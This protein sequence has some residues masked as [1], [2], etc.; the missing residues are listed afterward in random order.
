MVQIVKRLKQ[1]IKQIILSLADELDIFFP[2][3]TPQ[4]A[5]IAHA[6]HIRKAPCHDPC[7]Q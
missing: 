3:Q 2:F 1:T 6:A 7:I 5:H 4:R